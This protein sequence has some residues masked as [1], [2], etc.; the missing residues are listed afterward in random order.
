MLL[1]W[2]ILNSKQMADELDAG[3]MGEYKDLSNFE[4]GQTVTVSGTTSHVRCSQSVLV[5]T[6]Q[7]WSNGGTYRVFFVAKCQKTSLEVFLNL[8]ISGTLLTHRGLTT[9]NL[10]S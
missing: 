6:E 10:W 7:E 3:G 5:S 9:L 2:D 1:K 4:E 8:C